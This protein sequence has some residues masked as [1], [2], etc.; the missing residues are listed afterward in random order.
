MKQFDEI[1]RQQAKDAFSGYDAGRLAD[2]GWKAF[3]QKRKGKRGSVIVFPLWARA[4]SVILLITAGSLITYHILDNRPA[5]VPGEPADRILAKETP[6]LPQSPQEPATPAVTGTKVI[7]DEI[8]PAP[9][10]LLNSTSVNVTANKPVP[11]VTAMPDSLKTAGIIPAVAEQAAISE[12]NRP[13][14]QQEAIIAEQTADTLT[15]DHEELHQRV[16]LMAGVSGMMARAEDIS[17]GIPGISF[18]VYTEHRISRRL[19]VRPGILLAIQTIEMGTPAAESTMHY[20]T[21]TLDGASGSVE[22]FRGSL[23]LLA[24]E[25]PVNLVFT[26]IERG[27]RALYVSAGASSLF[28]LNQNVS[29]SF[30]N[31]YTRESFDNSTGELAIETRYS[32]VSVESSEEPFSHTDFFGL[33]NFSAG[34]SV[35]FGKSNKL[36]IEPYMQLPVNTLTSFNLRIGYSGVALKVRFGE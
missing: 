31:A 2:A 32:S 17:S 9:A 5:S 29:G 24:M 23:Q 35:P 13:Q 26:I 20:A 22:S 14:V 12:E 33:A 11:E 6:T 25:V 7:T 19:A 15:D 8:I 21:P 18:G 36:L 28:Y 10:P 30:R 1:F 3:L 34:Y 4:A 27:K 16:L